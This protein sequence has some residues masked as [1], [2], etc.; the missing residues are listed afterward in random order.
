MG[1]KKLSQPTLSM[2]SFQTR[3]RA[4]TSSLDASPPKETSNGNHEGID[5]SPPPSAPP[6]AA[7]RSATADHA[8]IARAPPEAKFAVFDS[9]CS[10]LEATMARKRQL[11]D[12]PSVW[13]WSAFCADALC[14][15]ATDD[16]LREAVLTAVATLLRQVRTAAT[17]MMS[18]GDDCF[19]RRCFAADATPWRLVALL[20][21]EERLLL[22][23][24]AVNTC[25]VPMWV[26]VGG[27]RRSVSDAAILLAVALQMVAEFKRTETRRLTHLFS[28]NG[29]VHLLALEEE[30]AQWVDHIEPA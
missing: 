21:S 9:G 3:A 12:K 26:R 14:G 16:E 10:S 23:Y 19:A 29:A 22:R 8:A 17:P 20:T 30:L 1:P 13:S 27:S 7:N 2:A 15:C 24:R 28:A 18:A 5:A 11:P 6:A 4:S 25:D